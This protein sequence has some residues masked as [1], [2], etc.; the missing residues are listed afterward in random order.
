MVPRRLHSVTG[1]ALAVGIAAVLGL[2]SGSLSF[3]ALVSTGMGPEERVANGAPALYVD[4]PFGSD[5]A[6]S[7][8][9]SNVHAVPASVEAVDTPVWFYG[10][11]EL[12][13]G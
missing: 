8:S 4:A 13:V 9:S 2:A 10:S 7:D 11:S 3:W 6:Q 1:S 12:S 5:P